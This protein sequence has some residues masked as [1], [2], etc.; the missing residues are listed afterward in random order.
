MKTKKNQLTDIWRNSKKN[1]KIII[2]LVVFEA[3][4][5]ERAQSGRDRNVY[6]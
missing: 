3:S 1:Y 5:S 2:F 4:S 6:R